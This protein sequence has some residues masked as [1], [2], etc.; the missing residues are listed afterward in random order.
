MIYRRCGDKDICCGICGM[1]DIRYLELDHINGDGVE[2]RIKFTDLEFLKYYIS[3]PK[4]ALEKL[5][6]LCRYCNNRHTT[7]I[8]MNR[9][10]L[11]GKHIGR[12][13]AVYDKNK[14]IKLLADKSPHSKIAQELGICKA[15]LYNV[16]KELA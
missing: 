4:D 8:G 2:D 10:K 5:R 14:L 3:H 15:T 1:S 16:L 6:V 7:S 12:P 9:A 11:L 13:K